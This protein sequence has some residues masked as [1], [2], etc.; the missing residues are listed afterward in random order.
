[1]CLGLLNGRTRVL[2][3]A[4]S[5]PV[6]DTTWSVL[7]GLLGAD[8]AS[9]YPPGDPFFGA[10]QRPHFSS[11]CRGLFPLWECLPS[12]NSVFAPPPPP[13]LLS[14]GTSTH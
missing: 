10:A 12:G 13:P 7:T 8:P 14:S 5:R 6:L 4:G 1:M 11:L 3:V 2:L 9:V